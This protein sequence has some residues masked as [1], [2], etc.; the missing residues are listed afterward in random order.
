MVRNEM[1]EKGKE[2]AEGLW[3]VK[4]EMSDLRNDLEERENMKKEQNNGKK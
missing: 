3:I 1:R 2:N 4:E